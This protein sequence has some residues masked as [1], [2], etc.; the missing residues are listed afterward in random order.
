MHHNVGWHESSWHMHNHGGFFTFRSHH[1][2]YLGLDKHDSGVHAHEHYTGHPHVNQQFELRY[3]TP[4]VQPMVQQS[5]QQPMQQ[6]YQQPYQQPMQ[7]P[8]QQPYQQ[9]MMQQP[10]MQ[11]PM[12]QQTM[13]G[14]AWNQAILNCFMKRV[15][16]WNLHGKYLI[17]GHDHP[18]GHHD[19]NYG[20]WNSSVWIIETHGMFNDRVSLK[21]AENGKYLCHYGGHIQMHHNV[22]WNEASWHMEN[23]GAFFTFRSHHGHYLGLDKHDSGVHAHAHYSGYPHVN[24]QFEVRYV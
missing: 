17:S 21:S 20:F 7:Q 23:H 10:M 18:H 4:M 8:M 2:H 24:Q 12:M 16:L 14:F 13:G 19:P 3:F 5:Y 15:Q 6:P 1:G 9:P 22:G 11:Q